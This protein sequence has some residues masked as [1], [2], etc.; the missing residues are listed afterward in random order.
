MSPDSGS[1]AVPHGMVRPLRVLGHTPRKINMEPES[2]HPWKF[3]TSS[4]QSHHFQV[5]PGLNLPGV[6]YR[7]YI[8]Q[9]IRS[10]QQPFNIHIARP[11]WRLG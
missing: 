1:L 6:F 10:P 11:T 5:L 8:R 4:S 2:F 7:M 9:K 3:G